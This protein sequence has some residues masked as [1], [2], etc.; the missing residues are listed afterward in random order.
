MIL[1]S[2]ATVA[3]YKM[4]YGTKTN[5]YPST[6][7]LSGIDAYI[8]SHQIEV[9]AVLGEQNNL[10]TFIMFCDPINV[11]M[12]DKIIDDQ[13][14]DYRVIGIERHNNNSDI[15]DLMKLLLRSQ[16]TSAH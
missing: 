7:T 1:G 6:P 15:D 5:T 2:N 3:L 8:E 4:V 14:R 13:G 12:G 9:M 16:Q 10:E 11:E